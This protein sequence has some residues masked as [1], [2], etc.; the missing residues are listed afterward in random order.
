VTTSFRPA[1]QPGDLPPLYNFSARNFERVCRDLLREEAGIATSSL[2]GVSGQG[3]QGIDILA[4]VEDGVHHEVGQCKCYREYGPSEIRKACAEFIRHW[5]Y[6]KS[7]NL[8][9]FVLFVAC[10]VDDVKSRKAILEEKKWFSAR[11]MRFEI[12]DAPQLFSKLN[13]HPGIVRQ[14]FANPEYWVGVICGVPAAPSEL[15]LPQPQYDYAEQFL[16]QQVNELA[17]ALSS[18]TAAE[19]EG[20]REAWREGRRDE[21]ITALRKIREDVPRWNALSPAVRAKALR[22]EANFGLVSSGDV[23]AAYQLADEADVLDPANGG[24]L[25]IL[26]AYAEGGA[27]AGLQALERHHVE[28]SEFEAGLLFGGRAS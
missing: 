5:E 14:Y 24:R 25:R 3:Q 28:D 26:F 13:P 19:V 6:W 7:Q 16:K 17:A 10:E 1:A 27:A 22:L 23:S 8:R 21:A 11:G 9:R 2:W 15:T 4:D 18:A 20:A 12:W